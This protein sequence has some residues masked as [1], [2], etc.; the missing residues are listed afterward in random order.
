[1]TINKNISKYIN[2]F[3]KLNLENLNDLILLLDNKIY[4]EDPFNKL[5][6]K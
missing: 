1:M 2:I 5:I 3:E 4:F 6:D